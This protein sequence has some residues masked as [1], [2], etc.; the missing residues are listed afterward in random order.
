MTIFFARHVFSMEGIQ[1]DPDLL[2]YGPSY[3]NN[4][5]DYEI[6]K[7]E[8]TPVK[9]HGNKMT[10]GGAAS[11]NPTSRG[12]VIKPPKTPSSDCLIPLYNYLASL[13]VAHAKDCPTMKNTSFT[14]PLTTSVS[15]P[16]PTEAPLCPS[17]VSVLLLR[18]LMPSNRLRAQS[19]SLVLLIFPCGMWN[20][21]MC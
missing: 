12:A 13:C 15:E 6:Y 20:Q 9:T 11:G 3:E 10:V 16:R 1:T 19:L 4:V 7:T 2:V 14:L 21:I 8:N 18:Q 5:H 17:P